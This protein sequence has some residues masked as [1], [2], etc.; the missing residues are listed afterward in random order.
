MSQTDYKK[1]E[2]VY[3]F[4]FVAKCDCG[5]VHKFKGRDIDLTKTNATIITFRNIYQCIQCGTLYD[6]IFEKRVNKNKK[7]TPFGLLITSILVIS[8]LFGGYKL[9]NV[10]FQ[11]IDTNINHATNQ[12][13]ND[14]YKWD[15]NQQQEK[16]DNQP[17]FNNK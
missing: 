8:V 13:L 16:R 3:T 4:G 2:R 6:G 9:F 1:M 7:Y 5:H 15:H 17:A 12:Q 10:V 11:P 14:F